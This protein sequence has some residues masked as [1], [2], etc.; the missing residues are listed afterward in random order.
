MA[1]FASE[2]GT[3]NHA[4]YTSGPQCDSCIAMNGT[5]LLSAHCPCCGEPIDLIVDTSL[6][7]Q[8]YTEDCPV[9]CRPMLVQVRVLDQDE[10]TLDIRPEN[11]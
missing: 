10:I 2:L 11:D 6:A 8:D 9:C 4:G 7:E 1:A 3:W 5:E